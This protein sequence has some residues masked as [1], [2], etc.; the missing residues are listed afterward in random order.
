MPKKILRSYLPDHSTL[1]KNRFLNRFSHWF[2]HPN[3]WHLNRRSVAGGVA[4]GMIGGLIPGPL[5]VITA[6]LLSVLLRVNLP[7]AILATFYTNPFTIAPIYWLAFLLGS[8]V[9][10]QDSG[11]TMAQI[12]A[13]NDWHWLAWFD[14]MWIWVKSLGLPLLVGLPLLG[15]LLAISSYVLIQIIWRLWVYRAL[16]L[17]RKRFHSHTTP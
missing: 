14:A 17:K 12:P 16:Y 11:A 7:V 10:G 5:Q 3:L 2:E 6:S 1:R 9:T 13:L 4:V 15:V 8:R